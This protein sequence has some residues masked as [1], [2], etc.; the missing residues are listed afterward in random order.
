MPVVATYLRIEVAELIEKAPGPAQA[1]TTAV[2][3]HDVQRQPAE[4][5]MQGGNFHLLR[6]S[7]N[8]G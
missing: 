2:C 7:G 6:P 5:W 4:M 3:T 1:P 8:A